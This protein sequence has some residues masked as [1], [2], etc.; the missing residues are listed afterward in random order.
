[1]E[2]NSNFLEQVRLELDVTWSDPDTDKKI[3]NIALSAQSAMVHQLGTSKEF[4]FSEPGIENTLALA[5][6]LYLW[7]KVPIEV[8]YTNYKELLLQ[9]R[10]IHEVEQEVLDGDIQ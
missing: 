2:T 5:Y 6:C 10:A 4:D 1:M 7:N 8:F 9:A 3:K